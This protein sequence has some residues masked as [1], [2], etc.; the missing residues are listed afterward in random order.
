M[1][2]PRVLMPRWRLGGGT[3]A[4]P[5]TQL[6]VVALLRLHASASSLHCTQNGK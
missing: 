6:T 3:E 2:A 1:K 5:H 4:I